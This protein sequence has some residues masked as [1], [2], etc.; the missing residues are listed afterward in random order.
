MTFGGNS[1][2]ISDC[3]AFKVCKTVPGCRPYSHSAKGHLIYK[4]RVV[5]DLAVPLQKNCVRIQRLNPKGEFSFGIIFGIK[6]NW[7]KKIEIFK[8]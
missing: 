7:I 4:R 5:S 3:R 6:R 1:M 8:Q 2:K